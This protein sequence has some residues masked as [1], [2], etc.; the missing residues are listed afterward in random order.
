MNISLHT[1]DGV[2]VYCYIICFPV[3]LA[4]FPFSEALLCCFS[5]HKW[6]RITGK[7]SRDMA[8]EEGEQRQNGGKGLARQ[9]STLSTQ[10]GLT[11]YSQFSGWR[12][13][14]YL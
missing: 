14:I 6:G 7:G 13:M 10:A 3:S 4:S 8:V 2:I 9:D 1:L 5:V 11:K 12:L